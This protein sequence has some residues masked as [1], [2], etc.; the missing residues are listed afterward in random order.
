MK[1]SYP[2]PRGWRSFVFRL[3]VLAWLLAVSSTRSVGQFPLGRLELDS[4]P[5]SLS[6]N[7]L[8]RETLRKVVAGAFCVSLGSHKAECVC[9]GLQLLQNT[10]TQ[11]QTLVAI[12]AVHKDLNIQHH[13]LSTVDSEGHSLYVNE[14]RAALQTSL[15]QAD[16]L[17][18]VGP[19]W[20]VLLTAL[21]LSPNNLRTSITMLDATTPSPSMMPTALRKGV[22]SAQDSQTDLGFAIGLVIGIAVGVAILICWL[23][24]FY[25]YCCKPQRPRHHKVDPNNHGSSATGRQL[26]SI[27]TVSQ[28]THDSVLDN[29]VVS[30][31]NRKASAMD[32]Q[33]FQMGNS[34]S[35]S[36]ATDKEIVVG[37]DEEEAQ[38]RNDIVMYDLSCKPPC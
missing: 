28:N 29:K 25:L 27:F 1:L 11:T 6:L 10:L 8:S 24:F 4:L 2:S 36:S 34:F 5:N 14:L 26:Q 20:S 31:F 21:Q 22:V 33:L 18:S 17:Q 23:F 9:D 37:E 38:L 30:T 3:V 12:V 19:S 7:E 35:N 13:R 32:V 16:V 15:S